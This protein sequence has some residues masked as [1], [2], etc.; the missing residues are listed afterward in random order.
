MRPSLAFTETLTPNSVAQIV[1]PHPGIVVRHHRR[2]GPLSHRLSPHRLA[3]RQILEAEH[4][5]VQAVAPAVTSLLGYPSSITPSPATTP[6][7]ATS[8]VARCLTTAAKPLPS[9]VT[10]TN[11]YAN[12]PA[13]A[14]LSGH[15]SADLNWSPTI[16]A[17]LHPAFQQFARDDNLCLHRGRLVIRQSLQSGHSLL[18]IIVPSSLRRLIFDVFHGSPIGGHFGVYKTLFRIRMRFFWPRCRQ[19]VVDWIRECAHCILTDKRVRRHSEVLFSWPVTAP[20]FVLHCDLWSPGTTISASGH[21]HLLSAMCD[22]TQFVVSVLIQTTHA[23]DLARF[24]FQEILLKVGMCGLIVVDAGSTFCG[25]FADAC[26][27][28]GI[29]LHRASRGNH[30]AVSVERFFR[31]L[32]KAVTI[33]SSDRGTPLVWVEAAMIATYAWNCSPIDGTDVV[34]SIP[35][36]GREF[37]FPFDVALEADGAPPR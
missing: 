20:M 9:P 15:L 4:S 5:L 11:A 22:L 27:L 26:K 16:I 31:Y 36:M 35:A 25:I 30:K 1:D 6:T 2:T 37:K 12:D 32:N 34:R 17:G 19:D 29:R 18:L 24:L 3:I 23:H 13:T 33:A 21:T 7:S 10:W 28:L 14:S 8:H